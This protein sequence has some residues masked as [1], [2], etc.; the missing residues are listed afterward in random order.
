ML[1]LIN[2][3]DISV[4]IEAISNLYLILLNIKVLKVWADIKNARINYTRLK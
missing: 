3:G 4:I 2:D 1:L